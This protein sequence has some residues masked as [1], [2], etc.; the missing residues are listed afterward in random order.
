[1]TT[2]TTSTPVGS[3][4]DPEPVPRRDFLGLASLWAAG[5]AFVFAGLGMLRLPKAAV[6]SSPSKKF[7]VA[8]PE[9]L[10]A[11]RLRALAG[12]VFGV[13][14]STESGTSAPIASEKRGL[15]GRRR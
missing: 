4:L 2:T 8:L 14:R 12:I 3:R 5:A 10:P 7:R 1:M 11:E 9:S 13:D 6:L 15:F